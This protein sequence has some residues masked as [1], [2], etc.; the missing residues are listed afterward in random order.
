MEA[1]SANRDGSKQMNDPPSNKRPSKSATVLHKVIF[2]I[3]SLK[4]G[5]KGSSRAAISKFLASEFE[6]DNANALKAALKRGAANGT[7]IQTG[8]SFRVASDPVASAKEGDNNVQSE[9]LVVG[10]SRGACDGDT[11]T[12]AYEG[13]LDSGHQFDKARSF[14][15]VLG[16]GEVI[17][18][19]DS[20]ILSMKEGGKRKLV[21]PSKFGYGKRGCKPDIPPNATLHFVIKMK[22]IVKHM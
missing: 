21:V 17:K 22:K 19:W 8:Q 18:G 10:T 16:A 9:D 4:G 15:F 12:V 11:I 3:R 2:A 20:G 13:R 7:L 1:A 5:P 14:T 6:Y